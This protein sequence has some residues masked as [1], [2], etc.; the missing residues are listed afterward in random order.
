MVRVMLY[1]IIVFCGI[2]VAGDVKHPFNAD[3]LMSIK[4]ISDPQVSP[5]GV[6]LVF[7]VKTIDLEA[8]RGR[9]DLWL[10]RTDGSNL[11]QLTTH[12]ENDSQPR[13]SPDGKWLYFLSSRTDTTQ[14][15]KISLDG[16]EAV[17]VTK[18]PLDVGNLVI[19]P[20]STHIA[21]SME[22]FPGSSY[23]QTKD[24]LSEIEKRKASG[25]V[26]DKAFVRHWNTWKD[27]RRS[28]VFVMAVDANEPV[29]VMRDMDAD[30][31][32]IPF[33]GA[34]EI[35][36]TPDGRKILFT[37]RDVGRIEPWS[38]NFDL[39]IAPID[40]S[41]KPESITPKNLA[42]D[43]TPL[44][45]PDGK[46]LAYLAMARPGYE[47]D[48][49]RILLRDWQT[50]KERVLAPQWD[51]SP[52]G[53][54]WS[55]DGKKM[56]VTAMNLGQQSLYAIDIATDKVSLVVRDGRIYSP[57]VCGSKIFFGLCNLKN[58][59]EVHSVFSDGKDLKKLTSFND[60]K[61]ASIQMGDYEQFTFP[62]WNEEPV[63]AYVLK[64]AEFDPSKQYPVAFL[65]HGGP[66][67]SFSNTFHY[68]WNPQIQA[69]AGY[70]AVMIDFHGS[71][72]Y[73]QEFCDSIRG[74]WGGKP[75]EDLQKG[76]AAA[77]ERYPW[78]DGDQ[79]GAMGGSF[80]GYMVNWIAG[81]WPDRFRCLISH[82]G[83]LDERMAYFDTEELWFPEW[84]HTGTPWT[85]PESYEK[86]N[87]IN[88]IQKWKAPM[89]IIHGAL[90]Y[91]VVDTQ[92]LSVFNACQ[93]LGIPSKLLYY[94]DEGHWIQKPHNAIQWQNTV[95]DWL[96][97]WVKD[98]D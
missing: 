53:I 61:L 69:G 22:V 8:D 73:G 77:L 55:S 14:V 12:P 75:L 46:T 62:G 85:N 78:M 70:A 58:P 29:D 51:R 56:F 86:H 92:G 52:S 32:S 41:S 94:P 54:C 79:V 67:G 74:D 31:P 60:K 19:S 44:F 80:G 48:R 87:P 82:A 21:F 3:D 30:S 33:G 2:S 88:H 49:F 5:D 24:K 7:V 4:Q 20:L 89:L 71:V 28:H 17:P 1:W 43:S 83:N 45:S 59:V 68:R 27:G 10:M 65:I 6:Y 38:T 50:G 18:L 81:Q 91:R 90:D 84:D 57:S 15:F 47:S 13:W 34:E 96:N 36:F 25:K 98:G 63:Y 64:P 16:G 40:G 95:L 37:A 35:S 76:L 9:T 11:K 66:Q 97:Q 93:R 72:G 26:Y 39:F 42:W 23:K